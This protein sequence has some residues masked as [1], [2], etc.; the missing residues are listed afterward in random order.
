M[1]LQ[2]EKYIAS[3]Y[4]R[5]LG[6]LRAQQKAIISSDISVT[7]AKENIH[8]AIAN[9]AGVKAAVDNLERLNGKYATAEEKA[10]YQKIKGMLNIQPGASEAEIEANVR[11]ALEGGSFDNILKDKQKLYDEALKKGGVVDDKL[12]KAAEE[13]VGTAKGELEKAAKA[14]GEKFT[15]GGKAKWIAPVAGAAILGLAALGLRPKA[16][17]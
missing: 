17:A 7:L 5:D 15:K 16:D 10:L 13:K 1:Q 2:A 8:K 12:V 3:S 14:L 9:D 4:T 11:K 6:Q